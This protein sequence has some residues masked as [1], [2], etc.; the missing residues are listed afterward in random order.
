ML[1]ACGWGSWVQVCTRGLEQLDDPAGSGF[2]GS[3][4][5]PCAELCSVLGRLREVRLAAEAPVKP[6]ERPILYSHCAVDIT[7]RN[8]QEYVTEAKQQQAEAAEKL[9]MV[10]AKIA[11]VKQLA[12]QQ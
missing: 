2:G 1:R 12:A 9:A 6:R 11:Q 4:L 8:V 7:L 5:S 3:G 10:D